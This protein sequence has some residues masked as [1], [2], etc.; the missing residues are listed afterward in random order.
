MPFVDEGGLVGGASS[1]GIVF[2]EDGRWL[3]VCDEALEG[4]GFFH[5]RLTSGTV[6]IGT[7]RGFLST[8]D[9]GCTYSVSSTFEGTSVPALAVALARPERIFIIGNDEV[10]ARVY[11]SDDSGAEFEV[12]AAFPGARLLSV[13]VSDDG[14]RVYAS[15]FVTDTTAPLALFS[16]DGG[17]TFAEATFWTSESLY[18]QLKGVDVDGQHVVA[19]VYGDTPSSTLIRVNEELGS[20]VELHTFDALVTDFAAFGE[21]RF[22]LELN[23]FLYM[24]D[25]S[26]ADSSFTLVDDGPT[27]CLVRVPGDQ[28]LWGCGGPADD[29]HFFATDDGSTWTPLL[30]FDEVDARQCPVGTIGQVACAALPAPGDDAGP[31]PPDGA[32]PPADVTP[33]CGATGGSARS[34]F[35]LAILLLC[36]RRHRT[37]LR[38]VRRG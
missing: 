35:V 6:L 36:L 18:V 8:N 29:F 11:R 14:D 22:V 25:T 34:V 16:R 21:R 3:R 28:R 19:L 2:E 20:P 9:G 37:L 10:G 27:T 7:S 13:V 17:N 12:T 31:E 32:L 1:D 26:I 5:H 24:Q 33:S 15:G 23:Q 4:I 30:T 38:G